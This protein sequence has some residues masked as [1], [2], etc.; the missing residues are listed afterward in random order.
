[1]ILAG[2]LR[3]ALV[4]AIQS[5]P[6]LL[7]LLE[8]DKGN[9]FEYVHSYPD[10]VNRLIQIQ[11]L[12]AP[13]VMVAWTGTEINGRSREIAHQFS[14]YL[15]SKGEVDSVFYAMRNGVM[16]SG[17]GLYLTQ[18]DPK[19]HP[20]D[21]QGCYERSIFI[22]D[23]LSIDYHEVPIVLTERGADGSNLS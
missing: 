2:T 15:K 14:A 17:R 4:E 18:I 6:S 22:N 21:L 11:Q 23:Q 12:K 9:I 19:C 16:N 7:D 3:K 20:P 13:S 8:G 5:I 1:M 10:S